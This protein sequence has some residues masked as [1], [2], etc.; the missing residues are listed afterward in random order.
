MAAAPTPARHQHTAPGHG[1]R[2]RP[3]LRVVP[4]PRRTAGYLVAVLA[5]AALGVFTVVGLNAR[6]AE[7]AFEARALEQQVSELS[8]RYEELTAEVARLE[9]PERLREVAVNELDMIPADR[10]AYLVAGRTVPGDGELRGLAAPGAPM[11]D[12]LKAVLTGSQ[13]GR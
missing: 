8:E 12:P 1:Q 7:R 10:P 3:E 9:S 4:P 6:A 11:A 2:A 5:L 13:S